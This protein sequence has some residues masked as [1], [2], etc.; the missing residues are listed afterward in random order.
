MANIYDQAGNPIDDQGTGIIDDQAGGLP[1]NNI[2]EGG[3]NG[4]TVTVGN[5]GGGSLDAFSAVHIDPTA[6]LVFSTAQ[7]AHGAYSYKFTTG[8]T[9]G[10]AYVAWQSTLVGTNPTIY[11]RAYV[12]LTAAPAT[13]DNIISFYG[14]SAAFGG[15]IM[16]ASGSN[17]VVRLQSNSFTE[18][19][20]QTLPLNA[21]FRL[22]FKIVSGAAGAATATVKVFTAPDS[23]VAA[24]TLTD[25]TNAYG[26]GGAVNE[27]HFG[28]TSSHL[29]QPAM[30]QDALQ[31]NNTGYPG[32]QQLIHTPSAGLSG[33]GTMTSAWTLIGSA[34]LSGSGSITTPRSDWMINPLS[35][36]GSL[37][38]SGTDISH[39]IGSANLTGSGSMTPAGNKITEWGAAL[40]GSGFMFISTY[41]AFLSGTGTLA[42]SGQIFGKHAALSG[43][44][45]LAVLQVSGGLVSGVGGVG[46]PYAFPGASQVAVAPPGSSNWQYLG[47]LGQVTALQY[48]FVCPG[49]ADKMTCTVMVPAT[50]RTQLFNPG[51][52]V[53]ITR[54]GHVV[55]RGKLDEPVPSKSG[56][57]LTAVGDGN[58]GQDFLAVYF[59]PWPNSEPDEA[60]NGA[61]QRG[62]PW[63][64]P[65]I[66]SP[67]GMWLG[68]A[69]DTGA[70]NIAALLN[71]VCTRG[72]L[73]WYVNSQP[74]GQY[75]G[76]TLSVFP[77]P[78]AVNRLLVV[79]DPVAR[80]LGGDI[81]TIVLRYQNSADN[82]T[83]GQPAG[84]SITT[85][86]NLAS[87]AAH[88]ALETYVDISDVGPLTGAQAV[89]V[90]N[91][92]LAI[93]QRASFAGPFTASFGQLLNP[94]G[95][96][97]DPG[98]DQAG[99]V[100]KLILTDF[101]FGGEVSTNLPITFIVGQYD[102]DDFA[103]VATIT[104]YQNVDQ[105]LTG[106]L[107]LPHKAIMSPT[108]I[109]GP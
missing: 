4:T 82:V 94:G 91:Q 1:L 19:N 97:I 68:Q 29:N 109:G 12:Y 35:G 60:V 100:V 11:G 10:A 78:T 104:P 63:T 7:A 85:A 27:V 56:W 70:Q 37:T 21:W 45:F 17:P 84:Y 73:T 108:G 34:A 55:W 20:G 47:T 61:I 9:S 36:S 48:S 87:V 39:G 101:G 64:N 32:P 52:Q 14:G 26:S 54:G 83:S 44:G 79:T 95:A 58:R 51:W 80:T 77:L 72:G 86:Q 67:P 66:G 75:A 96:P 6:A 65:G 53:R 98:T 46:T 81:N 42:N 38:G 107:G 105:S 62:L 93:Y 15:G 24:S 13:D 43:F 16:V 3:T 90:G 30:Y 106:L 41:A 92:I 33:S 25:A 76:N 8:G 71:L 22:D 69:V 89:A 50:Y 99:T 74:G 5:S 31:L 103:Q 40:S 2:A 23:T 28:W 59:D 57:T 18:I 88:G 49:G 102:W